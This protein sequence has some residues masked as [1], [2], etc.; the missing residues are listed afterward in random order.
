M[1]SFLLSRIVILL[2]GTLYPAYASYKALKSNDATSLSRWMTYWMVSTLF[3]TLEETIFNLFF[4]YEFPFYYEMKI[5]FVLWLLYPITKGSQVVYKD[6]VCP[7]LSQYEERIDQFLDSFKKDWFTALFQ[8]GCSVV[9][10]IVISLIRLKVQYEKYQCMYRR[11]NS[12][13][14]ASVIFPIDTLRKSIYPAKELACSDSEEFDLCETLESMK[15]NIS[16]SP[17]D[18][19]GMETPDLEGAGDSPTKNQRKVRGENEFG[20]HLEELD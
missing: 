12:D 15:L 17:Q 13:S 14:Q 18:K 5:I 7:Y 4:L 11:W 10:L 20:D 1:I 2:F 16:P 19:G 9:A 6:F 3:F 8:L